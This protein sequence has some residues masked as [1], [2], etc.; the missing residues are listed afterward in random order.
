MSRIRD[1]GLAAMNAL[2]NEQCSSIRFP[3]LR[4][5]L[6]INRDVCEDKMRKPSFTAPAMRSMDR[7]KFARAWSLAGAAGDC[8]ITTPTFDQFVK[9]ISS[10]AV[11]LSWAG[12][13]ANHGTSRMRS[14]IFRQ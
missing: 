7:D 13:S 9:T 5:G 11:M 1:E 8:C 2:Q 3:E 4:H 10:A 14:R 6:R 12:S